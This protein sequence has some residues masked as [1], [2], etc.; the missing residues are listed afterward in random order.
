MASSAK[1]PLW[2]AVDR[3]LARADL[4]GIQA[5]RLGPLAAHR[6][7]ELRQP[8]PAA[9]QQDEQLARMAMLTSIPLL[10]RIR[11]LTDGPLVL[12]K[13]AEVASL[14]PGR[15][16]SFGDV[17]LLAVESDRLHAALRREGFVEVEYPGED[18]SDYRHLP[19]LRAANLWLH[20]EVHVDPIVPEGYPS[21]PRDEVVEASV[22]SALG[23]EGISAPHPVHHALMLAA[24][25]WDDHEALSTLR[26]LID[27]AAVAQQANERELARTARAWG[28]EGI[29]DTTHGV[30][31]ALFSDGRPTAAMRLFGRHLPDVRERTVL[32]NHLVRWLRPFWEL[33][34]R[35]ALLAVPGLLRQELLPTSGESWN[36]KVRRVRYAVFHP[37]RSM[38]DHTR[39]WLGE[40]VR[41][42]THDPS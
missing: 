16:R 4:A 24:H 22:P 2:H 23:I 20:V 26:D 41:N 8:V 15:A 34:L 13:G 11:D 19:P 14:Y 12:M 17:D 37:R 35:R 5:H 32:E 31:T 33:P 3:L 25:G 1:A 10:K 29:W 27:V 38:S 36:A 21:P 42:R 6:L 7:R 9:L 40:G 39:S 18:F 28:I 30:V